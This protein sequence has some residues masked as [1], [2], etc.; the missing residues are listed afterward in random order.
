MDYYDQ[1]NAAANAVRAR[2]GVGELPRVAFVLGSGL[3]DLTRGVPGAVS[4]AYA[5]LPHWPRS[6]VAGHEGRLVYGRFGNRSVLL[7]AGRCHAYEGHDLK[8]VTFGV[9]V[10]GLL[11]VNVLV[12]TNAAGAVNTRF[13]AGEL[14]IIDDHVNLLGSSPLVGPGDERFGPRFTDMTAVYSARLRRIAE[15]SA[16]ETGVQVVR[17]VYAAVLGP[18]Y[19]TPAEIRYLRTI[20]VDAV[21]MSTVPEAIAARQMGIEV[22]GISCLTN[23]AAGILPEPLDHGAVLDTAARSSCRLGVLLRAIVERL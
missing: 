9:R 13:T 14:M 11:G 3:G 6:I 8:S 12:L 15:E 18:Q 1:V 23:A 17:G 21:G 10:L 20:G 22:L 5:D 4:M 19:E 2:V 7:L 16:G